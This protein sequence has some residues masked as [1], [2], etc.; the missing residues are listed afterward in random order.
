MSSVRG[1]RRSAAHMADREAEVRVEIAGLSAE[2][3]KMQPNMHA[4]DRYDGVTTKLKE[5]LDDLDQVRDEAREVSSRFEDVRRERQQLFQACYDHISQALQVIYKD[6]T[7]SSKHPLGDVTCM[8]PYAAHMG[9][10]SNSDILWYQA[11]MRT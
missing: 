2:L 5:C 8:R 3:D 9:Y 10:T 1:Q 7:R 11:A 4:V 6:L